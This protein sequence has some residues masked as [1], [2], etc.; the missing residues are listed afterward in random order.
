MDTKLLENL[1]WEMPKEVQEKTIKEIVTL[2]ELNLEEL[3]QPIDKKYW[4][5]CAEVLYEIGYPKIKKIIPG[6]LI[7]LQDI[8]WPGANIVIELLMKVPK[9]ELVF[10]IEESTKVALKNS[11]EMWL[12][13][14]SY[15]LVSLDLMEED[16]NI[17]DI[18][19]ELERRTEFWR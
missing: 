16:F 12:D 3:L 10:Y 1:S 17:V 2:K 7:W 13:N 9:N 4:K 5:N 18:Y 14:L 19:L 6:L 11:D 15:F 8:N